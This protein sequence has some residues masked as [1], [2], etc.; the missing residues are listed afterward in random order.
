VAEY[1]MLGTLAGIIGAGFATVLSFV[2]SRFL[3][4]IE[5]VADPLLMIVGTIVTIV[6]VL[7]VGLISNFDV[8]FRKPL[9][10]LR[11]Q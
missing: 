11:S 7:A 10:I 2:V 5:W 8:L 4:G 1:G 6:V 3:L 9:S